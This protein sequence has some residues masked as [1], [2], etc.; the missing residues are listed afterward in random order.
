MEADLRVAEPAIPFVDIASLGEQDRALYD[1]IGA[2]IGFVPN[3]MKTYL[4]RPQIAA[5]FLALSAAV[6]NQ[7]EDSLPR[8]VQSKLG[9]L[10]SAINGCRYCTSHQCSA[11]QNPAAHGAA[12]QGLSDAAI[13]ALISGADEGS[14][15]VERA[16]FA[17]A[18]AASF[19]ANS[20][21]AEI[22][23]D[24]KAQLSPGQIVELAGIVGMWKLFNTIHD[25][26]HLPIEDDKAPYGRFLDASGPAFG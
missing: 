7:G 13:V 9:V 8:G 4:H 16:C 3:S 25:S 23:D 20:V 2:S 5:A 14:D 15:A 11:L 19:D 26:L 10:C 17:Y 6:Y 24:L 12:A 22:L 21:S 18:R 1:R